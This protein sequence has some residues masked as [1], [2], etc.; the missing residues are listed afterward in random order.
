[1]QIAAARRVTKQILR[2]SEDWK[3]E[4]DIQEDL[5]GR[6]RERKSEEEEEED[7]SFVGRL[8]DKCVEGLSSHLNSST[9]TTSTSSTWNA[10]RRTSKR[11]LTIEEQ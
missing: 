6:L 3:R 7:G 5:L 2:D 8:C 1:V 9:S 10:W 4:C 11:S